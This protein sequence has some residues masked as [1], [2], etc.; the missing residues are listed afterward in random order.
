MSAT[1]TSGIS[2]SSLASLIVDALVDAK[3]VAKSDFDAAVE[4]ATVEIDVRK[5][6]GDYWCSTCARK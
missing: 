2:S 3:V 5:A 6:M 1:P 4:V